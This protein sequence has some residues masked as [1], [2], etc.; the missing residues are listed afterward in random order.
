MNAPH[1]LRGPA[2]ALALAITVSLCFLACSSSSKKTSLMEYAGV[3]ETTTTVEL[4]IRMHEFA[5]RY[6]LLI[7][8]AAYRIESGTDDPEI[9]K[10]ALLWKIYGIPAYN[11]AMFRVDPYAALID[12]WTLTVQIRDYFESGAGEDTFGDLQSIALEA[13]DGMESELIAIAGEVLGDEGVAGAKKDV[14]AWAQEYPI[15][16]HFCVRE[17]VIPL[18]AEVMAGDGKSW[19]EGLESLEESL[20]ELRLRLTI[21]T[22]IIPRQVQWQLELASLGLME[23]EDIKTAFKDIS[24]LRV[25]LDR[26]EGSLTGGFDRTAASINGVN[27]SISGGFDRLGGTLLGGIRE[28]RIEALAGLSSD[29]EPVLED[30]KKILDEGAVTYETRT[31]AVVNH[32]FWRGL[33]LVAAFFAGLTIYRVSATRPRKQ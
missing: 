32:V 14:Y 7:E 12:T 8:Q 9:W 27:H 5:V 25:S 24:D 10:N 20:Q 3:K 28:E 22:D 4:R 19:T 23:D 33:I 21:Y 26:M 30:L 1:R 17:S 11:K 29:M 18:V 13:A 16:N 6:P 15:Q 31:K 2:L